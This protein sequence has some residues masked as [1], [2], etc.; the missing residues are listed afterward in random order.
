MRAAVAVL[1]GAVSLLARPAVAQEA[2]PRA[3]TT[4][5]SPRAAGELVDPLAAIRVDL[6]VGD[7]LAGAAADETAR[8]ALAAIDVDGASI[9]PFAAISP[10]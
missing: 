3:T 8:D 2:L 10:L 5:G 6:P 1:V 7:V 4:G 9:D